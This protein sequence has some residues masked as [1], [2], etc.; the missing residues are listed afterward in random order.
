[1]KKRWL[2]GPISMSRRRFADVA[3]PT[4]TVQ[5]AKF[6]VQNASCACSGLEPS[7]AIRRESPGQRRFFRWSG[8]ASIR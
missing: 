7:F 3:G 1:M 4:G 2:P 6:C 5:D 8:P